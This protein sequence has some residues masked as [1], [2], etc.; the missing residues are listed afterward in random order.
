[1]QHWDYIFCY[2]LW[3]QLTAKMVILCILQA[4][5]VSHVTSNW[6]ISP[7]EFTVSV[8]NEC[9]RITTAYTTYC[10]DKFTWK[11]SI[12]Y[13][14]SLRLTPEKNGKRTCVIVGSPENISLA[15][16]LIMKAVN[17]QPVIEV[18]EIKVP[19]VCNEVD[20]FN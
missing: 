9:G 12:N 8:I 7:V 14:L 2:T 4:I 20:I 1:M 15:R 10:I 17:D 11:S 19:R 5:D 13:L 3:Y 6:M 18:S 16:Q